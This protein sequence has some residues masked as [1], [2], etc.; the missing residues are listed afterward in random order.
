MYSLRVH[1][2]P[3]LSSIAVLIAALPSLRVLQTSS[4]LPQHTQG[5]HWF[6]LRPIFSFF[7]LRHNHHSFK[8][9][10]LLQKGQKQPLGGFCFGLYKNIL[11]WENTKRLPTCLEK[12]SENQTNIII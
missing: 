3:I 2:N 7:P 4:A 9:I 12:T 10:M 1:L 8:E 6:L 11:K 5:L